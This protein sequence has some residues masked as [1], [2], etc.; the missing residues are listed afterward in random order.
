MGDLEGFKV[1]IDISNKYVMFDFKG[2]H[3][4]VVF[5][6]F[7]E[8]RLITITTDDGLAVPPISAGMYK[9]KEGK[10]VVYGGSASLKLPSR[11]EDADIIQKQLS[12]S[13]Q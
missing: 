13:V 12:V 11:P 2:I 9:I 3:M 5:P 10:V 1:G 7:I 6:C 4:P 8:H